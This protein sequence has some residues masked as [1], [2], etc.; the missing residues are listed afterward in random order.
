MIEEIKLELLKCKVNGNTIN[1]IVLSQIDYKDA[2]AE[3]KP[4]Q[5][6]QLEF[7]YPTTITHKGQSYIL[8]TDNENSEQHHIDI[9]HSKPFHVGCE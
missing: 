9:G 8:F 3:L 1:Q 6:L 4:N 5:T 2:F 7:G